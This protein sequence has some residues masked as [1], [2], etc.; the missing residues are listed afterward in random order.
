M[1]T[2]E[3]VRTILPAV[4]KEVRDLPIEF[5]AHCSTGI[6]PISYL[7]AVKLGVRS[8]ATAVRPL[9]NDVSL[10]STEN[11]ADNLKRMGH[12][13]NLDEDALKEMSDY[14]RDLAIKHGLRMGQPV[15]V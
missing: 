14:F 1:L 15:E 12:E 11:T 8:L 13:P 9:A 4:Q 3:R 2:P 7:E 10:P 6:A 5:H